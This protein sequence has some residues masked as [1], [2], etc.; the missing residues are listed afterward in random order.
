MSFKSKSISSY[1]ITI[2]SF[3][4]VKIYYLRENV[5]T[6]YTK[7]IQLRTSV[8]YMKNIKLIQ[9]YRY[10]IICHQQIYVNP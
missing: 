6:V 10:S 4:N 5:R 3:L 7:D 9:K 1:E 8:V 2:Y